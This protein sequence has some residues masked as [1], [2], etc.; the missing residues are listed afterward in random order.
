MHGLV[1]T[2]LKKHVEQTYGGPATW[3]ALLQAAGLGGKV[4]TALS[5]A[6]DEEVGAVVAA[7][8]SAT[9]LPAATVLERFGAHLVPGLLDVYGF[10]VPAHWTALDVIEHTETTI[11]TVVRTRG[12]GARPPVLRA[13]R[14]NAHH[15]RVQYS[16]ERRLCALARG[17]VRGVGE[18]FGT[19]LEITESA[20]MLTGS[21]SCVLEVRGGVV[22]AQRPGEAAQQPVR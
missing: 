9:G 1:M 17:I 3:T 19:P 13:L 4:Y 22:P 16:S 18:H 21:P 5:E 7:A 15:V 12:G 8:V 10:L 11:H 2:E 14:V 20:C 6:P